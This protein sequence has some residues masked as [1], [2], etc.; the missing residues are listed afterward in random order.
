MGRPQAA[1]NQQQERAQ[2]PKYQAQKNNCENVKASMSPIGPNSKP[3]GVSCRH[4]ILGP[5]ED[6]A[7]LRDDGNCYSR[8]DNDLRGEYLKEE[9]RQEMAI[10]AKPSR[11]DSNRAV[12][13]SN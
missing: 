11:L 5:A 13:N 1:E 8:D 10:A 4:S 7:P 2:P 12:H 3:A 9:N 6:I